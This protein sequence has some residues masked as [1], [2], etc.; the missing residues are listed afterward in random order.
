MKILTWNCN[1]ALRKKYS[2]LDCFDADILIIQECENPAKSTDIFRNWAGDYLWVGTS[3][4][5]GLGVFPKKENKISR[6]YWRNEFQLSGL[7][8][9][10]H[11][12][13]WSTDDLKLFLPFQVNNS[14]TILGLWTKGSD[15]CAFGYI[16]QLW[17]YLQI[18]RFELSNNNTLIIGDLNSNKIWDKYDR[19]WNHSDVIEELKQIGIE[20]VYHNQFNEEQGKE[21]IPTFFLYRNPEK[22]YHIDYAFSSS[23]LLP[24][25]TLSV[26]SKED[27]L[28][29]S[30]H[31]PLL[32]T[33]QK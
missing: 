4:H 8:S 17:K 14:I 1:G 12:L 22:K 25:C 9:N 33:L 10:S 2:E 20:S 18:H 32:L 29:V 21:T 23:D 24:N 3:K 27:W 6:L 5:K 31:M 16:G 15:S 28:H 13:K 30:D 7:K 11:T 19:W 26:G